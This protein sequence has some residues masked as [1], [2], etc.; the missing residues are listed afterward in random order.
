MTKDAIRG[1]SMC[2]CRQADVLHTQNFVLPAGTPLPASYDVAACPCCGFVYADTEATQGVYD[3]FYATLSKYEDAGTGT[4]G[5]ST[6]WDAERLAETATTIASLL[7]SKS[8][9]VLDLG[10]ANG[11]LLEALANCGVRE[12][13]GVDPSPAC[14]KHA[15]AK[16]FQAWCGQLYSLP[17]DAGKF[18]CVILSHVLE[19]I[20]DLQAAVT[21]LEPLLDEQ[22]ILYVEVPDAARY[23]DFLYAPFQDF[24]TEHINHFSHASLANLV[25]RIGMVPAVEDRKTLKCSADCL[26]PAIY[27]A[28]RRGEAGE[29]RVDTTTR[30][31]VERYIRESRAMMGRMNQRLRQVLESSPAVILWGTGQLAMKLLDETAL[32]DAPIAACVDANPANRG[33]QLRGVP[34]VGPLE[35]PSPDLPVVITSTL[36]ETAIMQ[37]IRELGLKNPVISLRV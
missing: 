2:G 16:G 11:G 12:L 33:K 34:I 3:Y 22:A 27:A 19:H 24:N 29:W 13:S 4:G 7:T 9:R 21:A 32:K 18:G 20:V 5:G 36:H 15:Q 1:C 10:C 17:P 35:I 8:Q 6:P 14:V 25:G 37:R 31:G 26:Y 23:A 28:Y 30:G